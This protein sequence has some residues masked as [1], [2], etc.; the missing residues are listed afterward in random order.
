MRLIPMT[1]HFLAFGVVM[2]LGCDSPKSSLGEL[3]GSTGSSEGGGSE[4]AEATSSISVSGAGPSDDVGAPC[5]LGGVP[6]S[7]LLELDNSD[8]SS[9]LCLY[10]DTVMADAQQSCSESSDCSGFGSGVICV[11]GQC[12]LDPAHVAEASMCTAE[13]S[14]DAEC[15]G[16]DGT[17]CESGF[18]CVPVTSLGSTCCQKLCACRVQLDVAAAAELAAACADGTQEGCCTEDPPGPGCGS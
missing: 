11:D 4:T 17:A 5:E 7:R 16:S 10:V 2:L 18:A 13:C 9:G 6:E 8:C 1:K 3:P 14:D 12:Q 15:V